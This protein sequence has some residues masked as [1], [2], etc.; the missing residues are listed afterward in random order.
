MTESAG[1]IALRR[2]V[3]V[4]YDGSDGSKRAVLWASRYAIS[5]Q[6]PLDVVH[7]WSWPFFTHDL[8]P[9]TGV[10]DSGLRREAERLVA[11]GQDLAARAE[12]D[13]EVRAR[14]VVGFPAETLTRLSA[15]ASLLV[16]GTRGFGGFAELL[17][18]SVS[19]RLA[20]SAS[21]PVMVVREARPTYDT[22]IAAVDG[23]PAS[24]RA[25]VAAADLAR[26]LHKRLDLL[27]VRVHRRRTP[28]PLPSDGRDPVLER[29]AA[30]LAGVS[31]LSVAEESAAGHSAAGLIV[32]RT[33]T[34]CC[35]VLGAK[36]GN[37]LGARLGTTAHAVLHHARGNIGIVP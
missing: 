28:A 23:S 30:Q 7:C 35:V 6:L 4:A 3:L 33:T 34:A 12:P 24:D 9:V 13:L 25:T 26:T 1:G 11:E 36:G 31:G 21:C 22:V 32:E 17:I 18:G 27:H 2:P 14:L 8:G 29:A 37:A 10:Q 19:L 16:T 5:A 20:S 15:E